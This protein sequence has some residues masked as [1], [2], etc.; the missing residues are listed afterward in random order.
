MPVPFVSL[1]GVQKVFDTPRGPFRALDDVTVAVEAGELLAVVG[2]SGSGKTT[3]L[4]VVAGIESAT[5]GAITVGGTDLR[6]LNTD[7]LTRWRRRAVGVVFQFFQLLPT[8]TCLE[9]VV[10]P[11]DL[12]GRLDVRERFER[13][14]ALLEEFQVADQADKR[15]AE[16]SGGQQ[17]RVAIARALA[18]EPALLVADEPSGNLDSVAA[19]NVFRLFRALA[20]KGTTVIVV[21]HSAE[22]A[23]A[24]DRQLL[25]LDG[26]MVEAQRG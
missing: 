20:A 21:T 16:L 13:G 4:H 14:L 18:N 7:G 12:E 15:P 17:Q 2:P 25:I 19:E 10:L 24:A 8:L 3:L 9:N 1:E 5:D 23:E 6:T 22:L 11:M 26:R